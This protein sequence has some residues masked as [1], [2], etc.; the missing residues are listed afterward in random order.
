MLVSRELNA[1]GCALCFR[2]E[3]DEQIAAARAAAQ[4]RETRRLA[5]L[6]LN[7]GGNVYSRGLAPTAPELRVKPWEPKLVAAPHKKW[8]KDRLTSESLRL[9]LPAVATLAVFIRLAV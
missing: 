2:Q 9:P 3:A 6:A 5:T 7:P 4:A 8:R 1:D